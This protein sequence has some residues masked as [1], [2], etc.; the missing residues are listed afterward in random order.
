MTQSNLPTKQ[1]R[2]VLAWVEIHQDDLL[3]LWDLVQH[4]QASVLIDG[5]K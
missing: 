2:L 4:G 3:A 5:L 1:E